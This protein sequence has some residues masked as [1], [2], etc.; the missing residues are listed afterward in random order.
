[1]RYLC[2]LLLIITFSTLTGC[3]E[4][5]LDA[6][7]KA[8]V[9]QTKKNMVFVQGGSFMMGDPGTE[10]TDEYGNTQRLPITM[11]TNDDYVHK[12]TLDSYY[13]NKFETTYAEFDLFCK[14]TGRELYNK[15]FFDHELRC[16][17]CP[18]AVPNWQA[19]K[20]Y[21]N[22]LSE[23]TGL[24]FDLPT[25]AQWEYAARSRGKNVWYA[26]DTGK[27]DHGRNFEPEEKPELH[28]VGTYPPNPLGIYDMSG[29][30]SEWT[31][32]WFDDNYYKV[33]PEHN[34]K[35]PATGKKKARRGG[36]VM[37]CPTGSIIYNRYGMKPQNSGG[38]TLGFRFVCNIKSSKHF[39]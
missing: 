25:E 22:W 29:N 17:S 20:D 28:R 6:K 24:P 16:E 7:I 2:L 14:A 9:E 37:D 15:D 10:V 27:L 33:S 31:N 32:D 12:V 4:N 11:W 30:V 8:L 36:S 34:P 13:I 18:T 19:A 39:E 3:K 5:E 26:T 35:G 23:I 1:M 21:C 38:I